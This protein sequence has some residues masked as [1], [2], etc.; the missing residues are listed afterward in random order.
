M[1]NYIARLL[2]IF[3]AVSVTPDHSA[4]NSGLPFQESSSSPIEAATTAKEKLR[5][6]A[7]EF[8]AYQ[9][10]NSIYLRLQK[11]IP[12]HHFENH[13][14]ERHR[15]S[16]K[17]FAK[18]QQKLIEIDVK[19]LDQNDLVTYEILAFELE[20][21]GVDD[22][23]Y[24]LQFD[25]TSYVGFRRFQ[26]AN[27]VLTSHKIEDEISASEYIA[28]L[29]EYMKMLNELILKVDGQIT[30]GIYLPKPAL[31]PTREMWNRFRSSISQKL[32]VSDDRLISLSEKQRAEFKT[33]VNKL[34]EYQILNNLELLLL[35]LGERYEAKA[36]HDVGIGQYPNGLDVYNRLIR[37]FTSLNLSVAEIHKRG[38]NAVKDISQRME[39]I[40]LKLGFKGT[41]VD[42]H[43]AIKQ[44][45]RFIARSPADVE[46]RYQYFIDK[47]V[48]KLDDYFKVQPKAA[49]GVRR[50]S[51]EAEPGMTYGYYNK[52]TAD[53][54]IGY[55][56]Y[57]GSNLRDRSLI[58]A[59]S[60]IYHEL[61]PGHHFHLATQDENESL[62]EF[63]KNYIAGAYIE[64]WAEYAASLGIEMGMYDE[65]F[66]DLY[67]RYAMEIFLASR[68]VVDTGMNA[69]GWSLQKA[70]NYMAEHLYMSDLE[71]SSETL[72]YSTSIPAQA[73]A[74][75]LGYEKIWEL[76]NRASKE[77]GKRFNIQDFHHVMLSDG[78]VPLSVLESKVKRYINNT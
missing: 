20:D 24:W 27:Q 38:I 34:V 62:H 29:F 40:R 76:R 73:L 55:Y 59:G 33:R 8:W 36:P 39:N 70:R 57:N 50:L 42:F 46:A 7:D 54:P 41:A 56:N 35:S 67:G 32:L 15:E 48:P 3:I 22:N 44:D 12:I 61:L 1:S 71:I 25:I 47:I 51:P 9:L 78:S 4:A 77:L 13:S 10:D 31:K 66:Y 45:P 18:W 43:R 37:K 6:I 17:R 11:G 16:I 74:F 60:L 2:L 21:R 75:R 5:T 14:L 58:G 26:L 23:D 53:D 49:Y 69:L 65:S 63:R 19:K 28:L 52:P 30:R 68:L 64:G 72:R